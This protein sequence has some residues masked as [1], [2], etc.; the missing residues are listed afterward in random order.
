MNPKRI[1]ERIVFKS[2][3][4]LQPGPAAL[5]DGLE[6]LAAIIRRWAERRS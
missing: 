6:R 5:T 1:P 4:I 3:D 2:S